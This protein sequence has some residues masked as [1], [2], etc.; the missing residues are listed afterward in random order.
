MNTENRIRG[1]AFENIAAIYLKT[2][3]FWVHQLRQ[4]MS[5]QPADLIV[6]KGHYHALID[7]K[8]ITASNRFPFSR[9]EPN[10]ATSMSTFGRKAWEPG[11]FMLR[12]PDGI[13]TM[14]SMDMI[15]SLENMGFNRIG[16][17]DRTNTCL[18]LDEW[19]ERANGDAS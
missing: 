4:G 12:W 14:L 8:V 7:C 16:M 5:G 3:G 9:I 10:Q 6:A 11:W 13:V 17:A 1:M 18:T 19:V 15:V 2:K